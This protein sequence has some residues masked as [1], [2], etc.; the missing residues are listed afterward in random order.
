[1]LGE[2]LGGHSC[3]TPGTGTRLRFFDCEPLTDEM[4]STA[5]SN[6]N[7]KRIPKKK[8]KIEY[9]GDLKVKTLQKS[10][11]LHTMTS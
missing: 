8:K 9:L 11:V 5:R 3:G 4:S 6:M 10:P 7:S 1:M 2:F